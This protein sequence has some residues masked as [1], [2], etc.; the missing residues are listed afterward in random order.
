M[1]SRFRVLGTLT[2]AGIVLALAMPALA[3]S[4]AVDAALAYVEQN[5]QRL[6]LVGSDVDEVAVSA[7]VASA[8][9]RVTHVYL[10]QRHRGIE[11]RHG[12]LNV[13]VAADGT[14]ISAGNR[15]V[16]RIAS[17]TAG[18]GARTTPVEAAA[19]AARHL[20]L[21]AAQ[22]FR[23]LHR[24][25]GPAQAAQ[26]S[27][28]GVASRPIEARLEWLRVGGAVRLAWVLEIEEPGGQH[29]WNAF[30]D[31]GTGEPLGAEDLVVHDPVQ[32]IAEIIERAPAAAAG[33]SAPAFEPTDGAVYNVFALPFESPNDGPR[34][35]AVNA[36][37]PAASPFGWHD[38]DGVAG[39]EFTVTRGNNVH[40]YTDVNA[41][42][43]EDPGS[44]PDGGAPLLF[45][46]PLD[47]EVGG[48]ATYRPAA[49][50]N[51]FYWNNVMHDVTFGYGFDEAAGNFQVKNYSGAVGGGDDVRAEAQDGSGTNNANFATPG[52]NAA[53]PRPRMQMFIWTHPLPAD[54]I[55]PAGP[56]AGTYL[57]SRATFGPQLVVGSP[58]AGNI[59]LVD[60]G[61]VGVPAPG[62][63][64]G[65]VNDGCEPFTGVAGKIAL[66]ERGFCNFTVKV[67]NAQT[68]GAVA[69]VVM[70]NV[71][72]NPI[73]MG[74]TPP[75]PTITIP[76]VMVSLDDAALIRANTPVD[77]S[78]QANPT[79]AINRDSDL[80][81]GVIAH[82]YGHGVSNRLTGGPNIDN[83]L[84]NAEQMGEGWSDW[85]ALTL[86]TRPSD[87]AATARGIGPYVIFQPED[88]AGIR[89][90]PYTTDMTINP[91]TY[92]SVANPAISQPH[93]IG[94]VWNTMLWET[95]WNLVD[96][97][98]YN[99][100]VYAPW[101]AGGNNLAL[102]L[103]MDG[104]KFQP[105]RPGFVDGR[106]GILAADTALTGAANRCEIWRAFAKRGLGA[107]ANQGD[108]NNRFDGVENFELP[109]LCLAATFGGFKPPVDD[110]PA[111]NSV[112]AGSTVPVKFTL[113]GAGDAVI[114]DSQ[115]VDCETLVPTG[116]APLL[117]DPSGLSR[118]GDK[119]HVNWKTAGAWEGT[120]RRLTLRI[121]APQ[122]AVAYFRFH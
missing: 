27:D 76:A 86:T 107:A 4:A 112:N 60:D 99:A 62:G 120:C 51:L 88:G 38:T 12:V 111:V 45:D 20:D 118:K 41:D 117:L 106:D 35:L 110:P 70:N 17:A 66:L 109:A 14:V 10:Q 85:F 13:N 58:L 77:G 101:S 19:T 94:Y 56:A 23:V 36:A 67:F 1:Q 9:N 90:T 39:P 31:A 113:A 52:Q 46:F 22:A 54:V 104:M 102:Q 100:D 8:H 29:W 87:T 83:C 42:N 73:T 121:A 3:G 15:F 72:G 25:G 68:A 57:A 6:G 114:I 11:V 65:T 115:A 74:F 43:Q 119:Y 28:G 18:Q 53:N 80:D 5:R 81:A 78:M 7:E 79:R 33:P 108:S 40:A 91:S 89:P 49:V 44:S 95:Y 59:V 34:S 82:E 97:Y 32:A 26:L 16:P 21:R 96:R 24:K 84:G 63:V 61:V 98:G 71:P 48:P 47:L 116:E 75:I 93:G 30:V 69:V 64:P 2:V 105:C 122:N 50:T 103:V 92:A 37:A 55:V